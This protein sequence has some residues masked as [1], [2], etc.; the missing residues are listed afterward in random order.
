MANKWGKDR[1]SD[2]LY[3][4]GLQ[5]HCRQWLQPWNSKM[6]AL[7]K[8][9]CD[10]PRHCIKEDRYHFAD[11]GPYSKSYGFSSSHA[12]MWE[13]DHKDSWVPKNWCS[14]TVCRRLLRVT[15][16]RRSNQSILKEMSPEYSLETLMLKLKLQYLGHLMRRAV[17]LETASDYDAGKDWRQEEK[18]WQRMRWLMAPLTR[19][20]WVWANSKR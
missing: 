8:K 1:N 9:N 7:W 10:K 3:F 20:A 2:R 14:Q 4:L 19:W 15:W 13:L 17:S 16:T 12:E 5:Y 18:R 6:L 11:K